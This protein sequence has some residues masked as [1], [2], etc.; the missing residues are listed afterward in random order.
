[1][2][3]ILTLLF[4]ILA[5]ISQLSCTQNAQ[6][7][8]HELD[9]QAT[10]QAPWA[11]GEIIYRGGEFIDINRKFLGITIQGNYLVQD[12]YHVNDLK[13]TDPYII[14]GSQGET[15]LSD[16][17]FIEG[18]YVMWHESGVKGSEGSYQDGVLHGLWTWWHDNG[19]ESSRTWF[20]N[21]REVRREEY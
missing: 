6:R 18:H 14:M 2:R 5:F 21:G 17:P 13:L 16:A 9:P 10:A 8:S 12:F 7:L 1:M 15:V 19:T 4:C 3:S 20:E 11:V